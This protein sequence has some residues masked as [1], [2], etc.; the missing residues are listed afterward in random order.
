MTA[1]NLGGRS[2]KD[3]HKPESSST[4][5]RE[6]PTKLRFSQVRAVPSKPGRGLSFRR[7]SGCTMWGVPAL[8]AAER[9]PWE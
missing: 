5:D 3:A 1:S 2:Y 4:T 7:S 9:R 8:F 6:A